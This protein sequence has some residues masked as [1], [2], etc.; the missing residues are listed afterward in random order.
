MLGRG[1]LVSPWMPPM[2][3]GVNP[4]GVAPVG[5]WMGDGSVRPG[6]WS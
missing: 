3:L 6:T 2:K 4:V 1:M 5:V